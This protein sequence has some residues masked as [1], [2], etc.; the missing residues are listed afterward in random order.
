M[1]ALGCP[2]RHATSKLMFTVF[3]FY[4]P[5]IIAG[6]LAGWYFAYG[7]SSETLSPFSEI[8]TTFNFVLLETDYTHMIPILVTALIIT[9]YLCAIM[10]TRY[11]FRFPIL[12]MLQGNFQ[13]RATKSKERDIGRFVS[14]G[15]DIALPRISVNRDENHDATLYQTTVEKMISSPDAKL[16]PSSIRTRFLMRFI[17]HHIFRSKLRSLLIIA[18]SAFFVISL[19][20]MM[21]AISRTE[22]EI[23]RLYDTTI[24][25]VDVRPS[26][27]G[28]AHP[29]HNI[30]DQIRPRVI[31]DILNTGYATDVYY[32]AGHS[33]GM[34]LRPAPDG[35]FPEDWAEIVN[36]DHSLKISNNRACLDV[37]VGTS[38]LRF[39]IDDNTGFR[40]HA[41]NDAEGDFQIYLDEEF[42]YD[43]FI[44]DEDNP[45][46]IIIPESMSAD[47]GISVGDFV[48]M[49]CNKP[50]YYEGIVTGRW[51][52]LNAVVV[53]IYN[54]RV[55]QS[56]LR[57]SVIMPV[58]ALEALM[59]DDIGYIRAQFNI[60]PE[61]NRDIL[62]VRE[63]IKAVA[64]DTSQFL[65]WAVWMDLLF[66][67]DELRAVVGN[68]EQNLLLL[69]L[70][71]P[72][73]I[74][75]SIATGFGL[76]L[77]LML[78]SAKNAAIIRVL[79][80]GTRQVSS[81][82]CAEQ[83]LVS[84]FGVLLGLLSLLVLRLS[85]FVDVAALQAHAYTMQAYL[86]G[87]YL[88]G[89]L[90]GS[91]VGAVIITKRI[92]MVLLQVRE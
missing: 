72:I 5:S 74:V 90:L 37:F 85:G 12:A 56:Q 26:N 54:G 57:N 52:R 14:D 16:H 38:D 2:M 83:M 10:L 22:N 44:Y 18:V 40:L 29:I 31:R 76:C 30:G 75:V 23:D 49:H 86:A 27:Q 35:S 53:G 25:S 36:Y 33:W 8:A 71:F 43:S 46:P 63:Q 50:F 1:R 47:K 13:N 19:G 89:V 65:G 15:G 58:A 9:F 39:F 73:A 21:S 79:G 64:E 61:F 55:R 11:I 51:Y 60:D 32:E 69:K 34:I 7:K 70:L 48:F 67:D 62:T 6:G 92:P 91:I 3:M 42:D 28:V 66:N 17:M 81:I 24:V 77:L 59:G 84:V 41:E 82:L 68:M 87:L 45:I 88:A 4:L 20:W 80:S 78:T